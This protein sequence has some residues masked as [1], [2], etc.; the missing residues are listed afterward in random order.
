MSLSVDNLTPALRAFWHPVATS[1]EVGPGPH[2]V[3][4]LGEWFALVRMDGALRAFPD[5][6]PHRDLP[7][8]AGRLVGGELECGYHGYRFDGAGRC[9]AIPARPAGTPVP[10]GAS[11]RPVWGVEERYGLVWLAIEEPRGP[12]PEFPEWAQDDPAQVP[13]GPHRWRVSAA[14][15]TDNFLDVSHFPFVHAGTF[16][17]T[18]EKVVPE[19]SLERDGLCFSYRYEHLA[20]NPD[21][22][23]A[24][25]AGATSE[26]QT[27]VMTFFFTP[28]FS[29]VSRVHYVQS[30]LT[31]V[32]FMTC[33][34]EAD[35]QTRFYS[36]LVGPDVAADPELAAEYENKILQED[37][38]VLERFR[39]YRMPVSLAAQFHTKADR[40]T[41]EYRRVLGEILATAGTAAQSALATS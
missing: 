25:H 21:E 26:F 10:A 9:T 3:Q 41:V 22:V 17:D 28:P 11:L 39:D 33:Q 20:R 8:S 38:V 29:L 12:L 1:G 30:G 34:P 19:I 36:R 32:V 31:D 23:K 35:G 13:I 2:A 6:C 18:A 4:L 16:G 37:R 15:A 5:R 27:R 14:Q 24:L 7:L 40:M